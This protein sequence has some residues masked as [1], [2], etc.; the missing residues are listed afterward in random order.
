MSVRIPLFSC[1]GRTIVLWYFDFSWVRYPCIGDA[2]GEGCLPS[3]LEQYI[4]L[5][6]SAGS[7]MYLEFHSPYFHR[8]F[9]YVI[10][11]VAN[12]RFFVSRFP[13]LSAFAA[14]DFCLFFGQLLLFEPV[15]RPP[16]Y[17][18]RRR[19]DPSRH[20]RLHWPLFRFSVGDVSLGF[21]P[22][23]HSRNVPGLSSGVVKSSFL[24]RIFVD[25]R[26]RTARSLPL[27]FQP[28]SS[29]YP[30]EHIFE[31]LERHGVSSCVGRGDIHCWSVEVGVASSLKRS[32]HVIRTLTCLIER[33]VAES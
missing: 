25:S 5:R 23:G 10:A 16:Q 6:G 26:G 18:W 15:E 14:S 24:P 7:V 2:S 1:S 12:V 32:L 13:S 22:E 28:F 27:R 4:D 19:W 3:P 9:G 11:K 8:S 20:A 29:R 17:R 21:C 31:L 30:R 33:V